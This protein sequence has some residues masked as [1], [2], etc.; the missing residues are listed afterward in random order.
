MQ[1]SFIGVCGDVHGHLQLALC[2]WAIEQRDRSVS[3][4]AILLCG[5]VGTFTTTAELDRATVRHAAENACEDEFLQWASKPPAPWLRGIFA[6]IQDGGLGLDAPVIMV[7]GNHEGFAHLDEILIEAG[8]R[9]SAPVT[10]DVL[11][12]VD[13][14]GKIRLLPSGWRVRT[15]RGAVIGGIGGIQ[16]GQ[17]LAAGY[18]AS[19]YIDEESVRALEMVEDLDVLMTHQGPS[20][21]QG[22]TAGAESLDRLL[23]RDRPLLWFHGHSR[24]HSGRRGRSARRRC[25]RSAMRRSTRAT[26]GESRTTHGSAS[27]T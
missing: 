24:T 13:T 1:P 22:P 17:R 11:P 7:S 9:P 23:D 5:D 20:R 27:C 4:D 8:A 14:L 6:P 10:P 21:V 2:S 25:S 3:L 16:P 15:A 18:P 12:A 19:A 26:D